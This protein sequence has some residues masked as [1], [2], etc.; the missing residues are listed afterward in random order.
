MQT[1]SSW[2]V[3]HGLGPYARSPGHYGFAN[4][5][6]PL[7]G[8]A[9]RENS[10]TKQRRGWFRPAKF[11]FEFPH[12]ADHAPPDDGRAA[13]GWYL[14]ALLPAAGVLLVGGQ[15]PHPAFPVAPVVLPLTLV[16][17]SRFVTRTKEKK[18]N[19]RKPSVISYAT[20][21]FKTFL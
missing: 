15:P 13:G 4:G 1:H 17:V 7:A 3:N 18:K 2:C 20:F 19:V 5:S 9:S 10:I 6:T 14:D 8:K 12:S 11:R 21:T 16:Y